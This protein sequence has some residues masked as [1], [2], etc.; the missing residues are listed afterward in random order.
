MEGVLALRA[1]GVA[2]EKEAQLA[3]ASTERTARVQAVKG[4]VGSGGGTLVE[5]TNFE[6]L[7]READT[8][9]AKHEKAAILLAER[10]GSLARVVERTTQMSASLQ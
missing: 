1:A 2:V 8:S 7:A 5:R 6:T 9:R 3:A 4:R 10:R